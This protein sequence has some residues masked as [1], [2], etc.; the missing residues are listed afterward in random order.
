MPRAHAL[1]NFADEL[2]EFFGFQRIV[3]WLGRHDFSS[4]SR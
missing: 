1:S 4:R 3:I 2:R